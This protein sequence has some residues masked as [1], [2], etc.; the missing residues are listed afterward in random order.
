M[1]QACNLHQVKRHRASRKGKRS[2]TAGRCGPFHWLDSLVISLLTGKDALGRRQHMNIWRWYIVTM[3]DLR[4]AVQ[5]VIW[6]P[7]LEALG[8]YKPHDNQQ[9]LTTTKSE[10]NYLNQKPKRGFQSLCPVI[11]LW[12]MHRVLPPCFYNLL[13]REINTLAPQC[14]VYTLLLCKFLAYLSRLLHWWW[15]KDSKKW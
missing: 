6:N 1:Q 15:Y 3:G 13:W 9:V 10:L 11:L 8:T 4:E 14:S 2:N 5:S 12:K 7:S